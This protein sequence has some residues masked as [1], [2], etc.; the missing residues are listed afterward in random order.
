MFYRKTQGTKKLK[1]KVPKMEKFEEF[2]AII[3]EDSTKTSQQKW[4]NTVEKK[5]GQK[6][7][8]VQ[9]FTFTEKKS[10]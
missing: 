9:G 7:T 4:M 6:L 8:N 3:Q 5:I 1:E 2:W 10:Y